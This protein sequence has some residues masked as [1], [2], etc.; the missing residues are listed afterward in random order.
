M[1]DIRKIEENPER[2]KELLKNKLYE[3]SFDEFLEKNK[4]EKTNC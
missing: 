2:V 1:I 4:K 3:V